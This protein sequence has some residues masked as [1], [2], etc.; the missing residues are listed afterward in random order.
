MPAITP[1]APGRK[2]GLYDLQKKGG[3]IKRGRKPKD[4]EREDYLTMYKAMVLIRTLD[5]RMLTLQ[6]QGRITF[7]GTAT[8][9]EASVVGSGYALNAS[10]WILPALREGGVALLRGFPLPDYINQVFCNGEDLLHGRQMPC[11]YGD[12]RVNYVT[13][14]S[15]IATQLPHAVG[16]AMAQ[17]LKGGT[18]ITIGYMGDG[19]TSEADFHVA[20][21]F[22]SRLSAPVLFFC[23]NNQ[24]A[25]STGWKQQTIAKSIACK[26]H[27]YGMDGYRVDG[28]DVLAVHQITLHA[29]NQ[30]RSTG[31]PVFI[32]ALTY[33]VGAHSTSDDPSRYRDESITEQWKKRD[34]ITRFRNTLYELDYWSPEQDS[35]LVD[36][37]VATIK[38]EIKR[39]E[40]VGPPSLDTLFEDVYAQIPRHLLEQKQALL[41]SL[42]ARKEH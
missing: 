11:H 33:R 5:E 30:I 26:A 16:V 7:Y 37:Y 28:N 9:Q 29:A 4:L 18:E 32:E 38:Q 24:W 19:A 3:G 1:E 12:K 34:P 31:R 39:A 15:N 14:S 17:K 36:D 2:P 35:T 13:L 27:G 10:D 41:A 40:A 23:Q 22:A 25:I 42:N 20:M 8:G 21:E 6:R